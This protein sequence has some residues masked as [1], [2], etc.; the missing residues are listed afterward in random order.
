MRTAYSFVALH[1]VLRQWLS[2]VTLIEARRETKQCLYTASSVVQRRG[3]PA[4]RYDV[5]LKMAEQQLQY[6]GVGMVH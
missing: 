6:D 2:K 3:Q 1:L 4:L 5:L